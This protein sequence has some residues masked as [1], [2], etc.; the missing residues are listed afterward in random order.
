M[1]DELSS[2]SGGAGRLGRPPNPVHPAASRRADLGA[3]VRRLRAARGLSLDA[4]AKLVHC[5]SSHLSEVEHGKK[6]PSVGLIQNLDRVLVTAGE[7]GLVER[8]WGAVAEQTVERH[9]RQV[10]R[11]QAA[12]RRVAP[13]SA[14]VAL[15]PTG[16]VPDADTAS[17]A[18]SASATLQMGPR[19]PGREVESAN[20]RTAIKA[21]TVMGELACSAAGIS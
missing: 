1:Q 15:Q 5:S 6:L 8:F 17:R 4:L 10:R 9:D 20:R 18:S 14:S 7:T 21:I 13:P 12:E 19:A 11:R 16:L 2:T 3:E